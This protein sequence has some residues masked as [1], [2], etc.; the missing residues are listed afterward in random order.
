MNVIMFK[1]LKYERKNILEIVNNLKLIAVF[2]PVHFSIS[3][4]QVSVLNMGL[5]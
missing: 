2:V 5:S 4:K 3:E 1:N